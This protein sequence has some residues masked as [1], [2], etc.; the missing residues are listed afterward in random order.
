VTHVDHV[1]SG[2]AIEDYGYRP[3][4][5]GVRANMIFSAD[6]AAAFQGHAGPLS[7]PADQRL[8]VALRA[9]ADVVLVGAGTARAER[10]GPVRLRP[11]HRDQRLALG[12]AAQPPPI[13]VVSRSGH[14]PDTMFGST[15]PIVVTSAR[16]A[17]DNAALGESPAEVLICGDEAVDIAEALAQLRDRGLDRVLCEGGPTLLDELVC[18]DL[19]DELCVTMAPRLAGTQPLG[20]A[21]PSALNAPAGLRLDQLLV[22]DDGYVYFRYG[23]HR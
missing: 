19:I 15:P 13:A 4:P 9:Y 8:L 18:A 22:D 10:Y 17:H 5:P 6:G 11:E 7:C 1:A 12:L 2:T 23:R 14:L 16:D 20:R 3:A 21:T